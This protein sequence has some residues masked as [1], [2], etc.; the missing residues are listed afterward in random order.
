MSEEEFQRR[1]DEL[2]ARIREL[3]NP[4]PLQQLAQETRDRHEKIRRNVKELRDSIATLRLYVKYILFDLE[5][6]QR[7]NAMLRKLLEDPKGGS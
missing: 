2:D 5:A 3:R 7:E 4:Q 6:T 1:M